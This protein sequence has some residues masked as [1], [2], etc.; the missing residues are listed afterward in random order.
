MAVG[1]IK[2]C[3]KQ[4]DGRDSAC[5]SV[6]GSAPFP[7]GWISATTH[8]EELSESVQSSGLY[9]ELLTDASI[10][11]SIHKAAASI[12]DKGARDVLQ[13]AARSAVQALQ[14]RLGIGVLSVRLDD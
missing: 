12:T 6:G 1:A 3:L 10:V 13:G 9:S 14:T 5:L 4:P 7:L 8:R 2:I 11:D